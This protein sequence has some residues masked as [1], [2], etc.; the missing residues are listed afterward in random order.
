MNLQCRSHNLKGDGYILL[1]LKNLR[2]ITLPHHVVYL[3][4]NDVELR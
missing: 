1:K 3:R 4:E 2:D